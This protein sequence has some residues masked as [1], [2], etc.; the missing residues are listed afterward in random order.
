M[1]FL[2]K[3][4]VGDFELDNGGWLRM[5]NTPDDPIRKPVVRHPIDL[6]V[7]QR[8]ASKYHAP[9]ETGILPAAW[10]IWA[11]DG[12]LACDRYA[13]GTEEI[14]FLR[15]LA[16]A[17]HCR[18]FE[19]FFEVPLDDLTPTMRAVSGGPNENDSLTVGTPGPPNGTM[20]DFKP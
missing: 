10:P 3:L 11:E 14:H 6:D 20:P 4:Y 19:L 8:L 12:Y 2:H 7:V 17:I 5:A 18:F 15:Q 1:S 9:G 13:L 16:E